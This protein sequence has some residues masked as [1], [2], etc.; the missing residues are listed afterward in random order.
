MPPKPKPPPRAVGCCTRTLTLL[1]PTIFEAVVVDHKCLACGWFAHEHP[2]EAPRLDAPANPANPAG[3]KEPA[4]VYQGPSLILPRDD[5]QVMLREL[6][7]WRLESV[8]SRDVAGWTL[9][10]RQLHA[11]I[12]DRS[13]PLAIVKQVTTITG[14]GANRKFQLHAAAGLTEEMTS[15]V[16]L[17][18]PR[19]GE[20]GRAV[21]QILAR[22]ARADFF[23]HKTGRKEL[24]KEPGENPVA[25]SLAIEWAATA[26]RDGLGRQLPRAA[27]LLKPNHPLWWGAVVAT[28]NPDGF[29]ASIMD[30]FDEA[31]EAWM[32]ENPSRWTDYSTWKSKHSTEA[33]D[34]ALRKNAPKVSTNI[35]TGKRSRGRGGGGNGGGGGD[36][37]SGAA[38]QKKV[39]T[40]PTGPSTGD[41]QTAGTLAPD[42]A[43][44]DGASQWAPAT[45]GGR[46][47]GRYTGGRGRDGGRGR[48]G[49]DPTS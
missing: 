27:S 12:F 6:D 7:H 40:D 1:Q 9:A 18:M 17:K 34:A 16:G 19:V 48:G 32:K 10:F 31:V 47:G 43:V 23:V 29:G 33:V 25:A 14:D 8:V 39:K 24:R 45:R 30:V 21:L 26:D 22:Q 42:G 5:S 46:G 36:S 4:D 41:A 20:A 35:E 44:N 15:A 37:S 11:V 28:T 49:R 38:P 2:T 13:H 3:A